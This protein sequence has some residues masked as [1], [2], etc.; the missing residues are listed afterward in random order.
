MRDSVA[1]L[2]TF[3]RWKIPEYLRKF[4]KLR[5]SMLRRKRG[6]ADHGSDGKT[7]AAASF[8]CRLRLKL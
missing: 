4:W 6:R 7:A 8:H 5:R 3:L 2:G 1:G